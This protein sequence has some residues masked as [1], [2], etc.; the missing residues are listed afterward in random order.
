MGD[1]GVLAGGGEKIDYCLVASLVAG[2]EEGDDVG[3][4]GLGG[5]MIAERVSL[6]LLGERVVG[7]EVETGREG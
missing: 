7:G 4:E 5:G 6:E 3:E 1:V 2:G